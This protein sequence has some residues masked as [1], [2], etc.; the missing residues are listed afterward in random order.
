MTKNRHSKKGKGEYTKVNLKSNYCKA[1]AF[2]Y[3]PL[4]SITCLEMWESPLCALI[5]INE[6]RYCI[7][8]LIG[9]NIGR[10]GRLD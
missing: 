6:Q 4:S 3:P 9:K 10:Q 7:G 5:T 2:S 1:E 8:L